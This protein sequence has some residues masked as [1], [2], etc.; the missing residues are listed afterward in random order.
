[1]CGAARPVP[2][3]GGAT[4]LPGPLTPLRPLRHVGSGISS[5]PR[6]EGPAFGLDGS[7]FRPGGRVGLRLVDAPVF[8]RG[9]RRTPARGLSAFGRGTPRAA[10][11]GGLASGRWV[12]EPSGRGGG[13]RP[14]RCVGLRPGDVGLPPGAGR[15]PAAGRRLAAG[16]NRRLRPGDTAGSGRAGHQRDI[17]R[18]APV[19]QSSSP[20]DRRS[21]R[22][23][24]R[25]AG[26]NVRS[27]SWP[28][29]Q[30]IADSSAAGRGR[31]VIVV[32]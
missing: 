31:P 4:R 19:H 14:V 28:V 32:S 6:P 12:R 5:V 27:G 18:S 26:A 2:G 17:S 9:A 1:M 29:I 30:R 21:G 13:L 11:G 20:W 7:A 22:T 24:S 25:T 3:M 10:A 16:R 23:W 15:P 8:G